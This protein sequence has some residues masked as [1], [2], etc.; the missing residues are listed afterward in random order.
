MYLG[1][2]ASLRANLSEKVRKRA[3]L[4]SFMSELAWLAPR[5]S[6]RACVAICTCVIASLRGNLHVCHC[7]LAW[8][9]LKK[10]NTMIV[11]SE[12]FE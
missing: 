3:R 5:V 12:A 10:I 2:I 1:A 7:E 6:L 4:L 8:Q 9:S 11:L